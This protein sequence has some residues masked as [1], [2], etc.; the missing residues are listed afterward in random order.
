[1]A[2]A[3]DAGGVPGA[4]LST[5]RP[6][7]AS[8]SDEQLRERLRSIASSV[9]SPEDALDPMMRAVIEAM[10]A[11][12]GAVCL[13]DVRDRRLRLAA[14]AGLSDEGCRR[15]RSVRKGEADAWEMPLHGLVNGRAYL[16]E[17]A[18][19]NRFVP[20][21]ID[22]AGEMSA[23][24]C[25][26]LSDG[27]TP[28]ASLILVA[29]KPRTFDERQLHAV[30]GP[31][32]EMARVIEATR[33]HAEGRGRV[34]AA[35]SPP[36]AIGGAAP[37]PAGQ[38]TETTALAAQL[39]QAQHERERLAAALA[40]ARAGDGARGGDLRSEIDRLRAQLGEAE[41]GAAHERRAREELETR[42]AGGASAGRHELQRAEV[43]LRE[44]E[45]ARAA[46]VAETARLRADLEIA[47]MEAAHR[48]VPAAE[49]D[50]RITELLA[51]ID[52][53]RASLA[54][55]EA[56]AAHEQRAREEIESRLA[57][58]S[59]AGQEELRRVV[60]AAR[61]AE[62][63]RAAAIAEVSRL[64]TE[65][66]LARIE[67]T[68][69]PS[70]PGQRDDR[71]GPLLAEIDRLRARLAEAEAGAA[72]EHRARDE[73]ET[74]FTEGVTTGQQDLRHALEAA[75]RAEEAR[76]T[77]LAEMGRLRAELERA[78]T[79]AARAP[80]PT[81]EVDARI[82]DLATEID[83]LRTQV[84]EAEAGAAHQHRAREEL[85]ARLTGDGNAGQQELRKALERAR[86][87]EQARA[88]ATAETTR[89]GAELERVRLTAVQTP[90]HV[91]EVAA[92]SAAQAAEIDR[93][94]TRL[95]E[96][97]AGA[98]H[99]HRAREELEARLVQATTAAHEDLQRARA[100]ADSAEDARGAAEA[101]VVRLGA[102]LRE[103]R[104]EAARLPEIRS[105]AETRATEL[106][107]ELDRLAARLA[108]AEALATEEQRA[109][110]GLEARLVADVASERRERDLALAE[111]RE[112]ATAA[113]RGEI[114]RLSAELETARAAAARA[115]MH[116]TA[117]AESE[118]VRSE[119]ADALHATAAERAELVRAD[120]ETAGALAAEHTAEIERLRARLADAEA[121]AAREQRAREALAAAAAHDLGNQGNDL[122]LAL[123]AARAAEEGRD[124][125]VAERAAALTHVA[126][127]ENEITLRRTE[128]ARL[129]AEARDACEARDERT[130]ALAV[131]CRDR[132][133]TAA[134][135]AEVEDLLAT[136]QAK[137]AMMTT[138]LERSERERD[139][140]H[141]AHAAAGAERD[142]LAAELGGSAAAKT[143]VEE[144]LAHVLERD[145][146]RE[147]ALAEACERATAVTARLAERE[148]DLQAL[149]EMHAADIV[150]L[151]ARGNALTSEIRSLQDAHGAIGADRD[152]L[153][154]ELEGIQAAKAHLERSFQQAV[155]ASRD[156]EQTAID[157]AENFARQ[158]AAREAELRALAEQRA[159]E[160]AE[161]D[162]RVDALVAEADGLRESVAA[163]ATER[164][165]L[166]AD[167]QGAAAG[168]VHLEHTLEHA[169]EDARGTA[170][171][172]LEARA[173]VWTLS[174]RLA[175]T[176]RAS[177]ALREEYTTEIATLTDR[178]Q[179]LTAT[180]DRLREAQAAAG[181]TCDRLAA[182]LQGSAAAKAHLEEA[183]QT[184]LE[185]ARTRG[186]EA[187]EQLEEA[188]ALVWMTAVRRAETEQHLI[189]LGE[190]RIAEAGAFAVLAE[191]LESEADR[192][193][194]LAAAT[195]SERNRLAAD[196]GGAAAAKA[197]LE[198]TLKTVL[199]TSRAREQ[200]ATALLQEVRTQAWATA[201]RLTETEVTLRAVD[202]ERTAEVAVLT[203]RTQ[204]LT[205]D[206]ERMREAEGA[207][208]SE[209]DHLAAELAGARAAHER[210]EQTL[211]QN[212][213]A[214]RDREEAMA[215]RL[216]EL[217]REVE[218][219]PATVKPA[220]PAKA[221]AG[222]A[223][224]AVDPPPRL[225]AEAPA[226][227]SASGVPPAAEEVAVLDDESAW[228]GVTV[229]R[230]QTTI[231]AP[232]AAGLARLAS[233]RPGVVLVNLAA[234]GMMKTL[235]SVRALGPRTRLFG[236]LA[237][238]GSDGALPLGTLAPTAR[239]L[240][241]DAVVA[242]LASR[243]PARARV[244][245]VSADVDAML[246]LRQALGRQGASVSLA[247]DAKQ[248]SD[249]LDMVHPHVVVAD[250]EMGRDVG[251]VLARLAASQP[252][253]ILV[254]IE[255][256]ADCGPDL[257]TVLGNP[258]VASQLVSRK[259]LLGAVLGRS[260]STP[261]KAAR[262][263]G[264]LPA[265]SVAR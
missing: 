128:N 86:H 114:R 129:G 67:A 185:E 89:L 240:E 36:A 229:D 66:E 201:V 1:M 174:A 91:A 231:F 31:L 132:E 12:A 181:A 58:D 79:D 127:L 16:I 256:S 84:A 177:L 258:E 27:E 164:D 161:R 123:E 202:E 198:E 97:E 111:T 117:L 237:R 154:A 200:D 155:E 24:V 11:C 34:S 54:Q 143:R 246:S 121:C 45:S 259:D 216:A 149:H 195:D 37:R 169:L 265:R 46:A 81:D 262:P 21:L 264:P 124:Q 62:Q 191:T 88:T 233:A 238:S 52:Q 250:L 139:R 242:A 159:T 57:G 247:W 125:A 14:E 26:P 55:A 4:R 83:R 73:L 102:E 138:Q 38:T 18:S 134:R 20:P 203:A 105:E 249:L 5:P 196:L 172:L 165:R 227:R 223:R 218:T 150:A 245:T 260:A 146:A 230:P 151:T 209:R 130:R 95:A 110:A 50:V 25:L 248:A 71:I 162:L 47:R 76:A 168:K 188:R 56:G 104:A 87:A 244:V 109:R 213:T 178:V 33:R 211:A 96:A 63:A 35:P 68:P 226:P 108:E 175:E 176:E 44:A 30:E 140:L 82:V 15:L 220:V 17:N 13:F 144:A 94:H 131:A 205:A 80:G 236:Y 212:L 173:Q 133:E 106:A 214:S 113:A 74:R 78:R 48:P 118:R 112:N 53:L 241:P 219:P 153:A 158:L 137:R 255:G 152:R 119:L 115:E 156:R 136:I 51:Q 190:E 75:R 22:D 251:I 194:A 254:L 142:R 257:A 49:V 135:L 101:E 23:V 199:E 2:L 59:H 263:G 184:A 6:T 189:A 103:A 116:A 92:R 100:A 192:W 3:S 217:E 225:V 8:A 19:R 204:A 41:A 166:A 69:G 215:A 207:A 61:A 180:V 126:S 252:V 99:E 7:R 122:R 222:N 65:L 261:S 157:R 193:R 29:L 228:T 70:A 145:T 77:T 93:L 235:A 210:L 9:A 141:Q 197:H 90:E 107:R 64:R 243:V 98:A 183:L 221:D 208:A 186:Q 42:F 60:A 43:A 163:F 39:A 206:A 40:A 10:G 28:L 147:R 85:E 148:A 170:H 187:T 232:D 179:T 239:P 171:D 32:Q 224:P 72:H 167:L 160:V 253:P 120:A 182:D 234:V